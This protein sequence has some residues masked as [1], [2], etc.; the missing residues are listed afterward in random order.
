MRRRAGRE[1]PDEGW[2]RNGEEERECA[3]ARGGRKRETRWQGDGNRRSAPA[4]L[5][6]L[7]H[8]RPKPVG[9]T[10]AC[11]PSPSRRLGFKSPGSCYHEPLDRTPPRFRP[12]GPTTSVRPEPIRAPRSKPTRHLSEPPG[13]HWSATAISPGT[14]QSTHSTRSHRSMVNERS[15]DGQLINGGQH[16]GRWRSLSERAQR[17]PAPILS[18]TESNRSLSLPLSLILTYIIISKIIIHYRP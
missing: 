10:E 13:D 5:L 18:S 8:T 12:A 7:L 17:S 16:H 11:G 4:S 1:C 14:S 2:S 6:R 15:T 9:G 3:D